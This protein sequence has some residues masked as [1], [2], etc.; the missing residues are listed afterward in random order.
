[1]ST[2]KVEPLVGVEVT[3]FPAASSAADIATVA[4]PSPLP[5]V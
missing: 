3:T 1:M 2:V 5:I 4:V